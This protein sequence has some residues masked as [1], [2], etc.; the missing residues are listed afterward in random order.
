MHAGYMCNTCADA[1]THRIMGP[2]PRKTR[3]E[4]NE[5]EKERREGKKERKKGR[6]REGGETEAAA[7]L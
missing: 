1:C 6:E 3:R 7:G 2:V 4:G 5:E